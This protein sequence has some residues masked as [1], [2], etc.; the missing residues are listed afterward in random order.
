M[1]T[2]LFVDINKIKVRKLNINKKPRDV[3]TNVCQTE[4]GVGWDST[5]CRVQHHE[6]HGSTAA[7]VS[8]YVVLYLRWTTHSFPPPASRAGKHKRGRQGT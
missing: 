3:G 8:M 6:Q 1:P 7:S 4:H 2:A 5:C